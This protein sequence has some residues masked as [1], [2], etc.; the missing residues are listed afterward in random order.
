M[1][2]QISEEIATVRGIDEH[3]KTTDSLRWALE[4][5]AAE[6]DAEEIV[7]KNCFVLSVDKAPKILNCWYIYIIWKEV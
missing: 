3:L 7:M 5:N 2:L 6:R 1:V 4:M